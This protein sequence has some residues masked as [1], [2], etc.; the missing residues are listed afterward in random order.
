[1]NGSSNNNVD[2]YTYDITVIIGKITLQQLIT[3]WLVALLDETAGKSSSD[4][5]YV[6]NTSSGN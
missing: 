1:M 5:G 2:T 3:P 6:K 4:G